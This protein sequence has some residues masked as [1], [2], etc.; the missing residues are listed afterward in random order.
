M[1]IEQ[2][3]IDWLKNDKNLHDVTISADMPARDNARVI[4][5]EQIGA[6]IGNVTDA[7]TLTINGYASTRYE[8]SKLMHTLIVPRLSILYQIPVVADYQIN[9]IAHYPDPG[10]PVRERYTL[11]LLITTSKPQPTQF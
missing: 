6:S 1:I 4:T 10:P 3:V 2:I 7:W 9:A 8:C 5:V 11:T